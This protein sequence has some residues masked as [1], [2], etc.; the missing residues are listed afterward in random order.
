MLGE[1]PIAGFVS[2]KVVALLCYL[3][4][5]EGSHSRDALAGL[6]WGEMPEERARANLRMA[7][8]NLQQLLPGYFTVTRTSVAFDRQQPF[9]LDVDA[10]ESA[11]ETKPVDLPALRE[12]VDLYRGDILE[13]IFV[14][15]ASEFETWLLNRREHLR[16]LALQALEKLVSKHILRGEWSVVMGLARR[17]LSIE[18]WHEAAHRHVMNAFA[19]TGD[20]TAALAQFE[21]CRRTLADELGVDPAPETVFLYERIRQV[22]QRPTRH[23]LPPQF[24]PFIGRDFELRQINRLL[25]DPNCRLLTLVGPGGIG[26]SRIA[27]QAARAQ[28][29]SY[30]D[31]VYLVPLAGLGSAGLLASAILSALGLELHGMTEPRTQLLNYLRGREFL[32]LLDSFEHLLE[33]TSL[34]SKI[35]EQTSQVKMLVTSRERLNVQSEWVFPVQGLEYPRSGQKVGIEQYSAVTLFM[36]TARRVETNFHLDEAARSYVARI[37]RLVG[38]MPLALELA[39]SWSSSLTCYEI[40]TEIERGIN[41]LSSSKRD[42]PERHRSIRAVFDHSWKLLSENEQVVL[43]RLSVFRGGFTRQAAEQ[44]AGATLSTLSS[45][46]NKSLLQTSSHLKESQRYDMHDLV[47]QYTEEHLQASVELDEIQ[48]RHLVYFLELAENADRAVHTGE[49]ADWLVRLEVEIDNLR[50]AMSW[51]QRTPIG[52]EAGMRLARGL[53]W[54]SY[55]SN[56]WREGRE[57]AERMLAVPGAVEHRDAWASALF[58]AG[59]LALLLDDYEAAEKQLQESLLLLRQGNNV[60]ELAYALSVLGEARVNQGEAVSAQALEEESAGLFQ[61]IEDK[62]GYLFAISSLGDVLLYLGEYERARE[63]FSA[64]LGLSQELENPVGLAY[65]LL[66]LGEI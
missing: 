33:G 35:L 50:T 10:F 43:S 64:C 58:T 59:G 61:T 1:E 3:A 11:I 14:E 45:L 52:P 29:G 55:F 65:A 19:R 60:R 66:N 38:G 12:A 2:D 15:G 5:N 27:L 62:P 32:I 17:I 18:P 26:K 4:L 24:T 23:N 41:I 40:A 36:E 20:F 8:Y 22:R 51:A 44:V 49:Y 13:G 6:L 7:L 9:W 16:L 42:L 53:A 47:R 28:T 37:C 63:T 25:A 48:N 56:R 46:I 30:L 31:G 54:F 21:T 57:W 39:A 34:L